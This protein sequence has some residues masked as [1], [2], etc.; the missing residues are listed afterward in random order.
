MGN[1]IYMYIYIFKNQS[2]HLTTIPYPIYPQKHPP[3]KQTHQDCFFADNELWI[4]ME[5]C[6]GGSVADTLDATERT[7]TEPQVGAVCPFLGGLG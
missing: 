3:K 4:V 2:I 1:Y 6:L 7:L 5:F